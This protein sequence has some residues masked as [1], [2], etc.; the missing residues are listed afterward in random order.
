MQTDTIYNLISAAEQWALSAKHDMSWH[1]QQHKQTTTKSALDKHMLWASNQQ[2]KMAT[3]FN[4][5][6]YAHASYAL[7]GV[8]DDEY[9][10]AM[11]YV[12]YLKNL[13]THYTHESTPSNIK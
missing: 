11:S 13:V 8:Q 7:L 12:L 9:S 3:I 4:P 1:M 10:P 6:G 5:R 2:N